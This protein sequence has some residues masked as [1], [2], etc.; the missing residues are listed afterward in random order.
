MAAIQSFKR[1]SP[2]D[3]QLFEDGKKID[4]VSWMRLGFCVLMLMVMVVLLLQAHT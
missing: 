1:F 4:P 2:F 3:C